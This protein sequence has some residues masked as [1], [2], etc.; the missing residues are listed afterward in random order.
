MACTCFNGFS[1]VTSAVSFIQSVKADYDV[2][3][4]W[5]DFS[6]SHPK[7]NKT[8]ATGTFAQEFLKCLLFWRRGLLFISMWLLCTDSVS[9]N[10][11]SEVDNFTSSLW[12]QSHTDTNC[13]FPSLKAYRSDQ[14]SF[15]SKVCFWLISQFWLKIL[16]SYAQWQFGVYRET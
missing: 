7:Y 3:K 6:H 16:D 5:L 2:I 1:P 14:H 4:Q 13:L 15:P 9:T 10:D 8:E 11:F 12:P